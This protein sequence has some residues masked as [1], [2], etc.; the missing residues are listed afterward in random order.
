MNVNETLNDR[1]EIYGDYGHNVAT[2]CAVMNALSQLRY[3]KAGTVFTEE[4]R[5]M[6]QDLVFK[7]VRFA[8]SP[9]HVDSVHDIAGYATLIER[10]LRKVG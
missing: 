4:E 9:D 7:L 1:E 3:K 8:A 5:V 6:I 2:R 10:E